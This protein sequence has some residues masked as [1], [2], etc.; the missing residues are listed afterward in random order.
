MAEK[1]KNT[2]SYAKA[3][4]DVPLYEELPPPGTKNTAKKKG[5]FVHM[6]RLRENVHNNPQYHPT[7]ERETSLLSSKSQTTNLFGGIFSIPFQADQDFQDK[8][9]SP[10]GDPMSKFAGSKEVN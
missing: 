7:I 1:R 4:L 10:M 5:E 3:N 2:R 8:L 9:I 6:W